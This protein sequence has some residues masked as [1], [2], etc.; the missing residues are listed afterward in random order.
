MLM[1]DPIARDVLWWL[2][3][4]AQERNDCRIIYPTPVLAEEMR[5]GEGAVKHALRRLKAAGLVVVVGRGDFDQ[6]LEILAVVEA[7]LAKEVAEKTPRNAKIA[8]EVSTGDD[9]GIQKPIGSASDRNRDGIGSQ[10]DRDRVALVRARQEQRTK[11]LEQDQGSSACAPATP[12]P[13]QPDPA[14]AAWAMWEAFIAERFKAQV[15][16]ETERTIIDDVVRTFGLEHTQS[17]IAS[18]VD[19]RARPPVSWVRDRAGKAQ[20]QAA[21]PSQAARPATVP[22]HRRAGLPTATDKAA[23]QVDESAEMA[24][25]DA[26]IARLEA[27]AA[28]DR[29]RIE[30]VAPKPAPAPSPVAT[31]ERIASPEKWRE[32]DEATRNLFGPRR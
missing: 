29:A 20:R 27:E 15:M 11:N 16:P 13:E 17:A 3:D 10:S 23:A 26:E 1:D 14:A 18:L 30:A 24:R 22:T 31:P 5:R 32:L 6:R 19:A 8:Q 25:L 7:E 2:A 28:R 21:Q 4:A 9:S 12:A